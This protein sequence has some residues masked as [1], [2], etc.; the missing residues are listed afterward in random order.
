MVVCQDDLHPQLFCCPDLFHG[1]DAAID[2]DDQRCASAPHVVDGI[3]VETV[4]VSDAMGDV[5][6]GGAA[7]LLQRLVEQHSGRNTVS[8]EV[9]EHRDGFAVAYRLQDA[10]YGDVHVI[11]EKRVVE[12]VLRGV[13]HILGGLGVLNASIVQNL[14]PQGGHIQR[15]DY[16]IGNRRRHRPKRAR[17]RT[18]KRHDVMGPLVLIPLEHQRGIVATKPKGVGHGHVHLGVTG[19]VGRIVQVAFRVWVL[20]VGRRRDAAVHDGHRTDG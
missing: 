5:C 14:R 19:L 11:E 17:Y 4:P 8:I 16:I 15:G 13:Q 12:G 9:A 18:L 20:K 3:D 2:G 7:Q 1:G 10:T 6:D